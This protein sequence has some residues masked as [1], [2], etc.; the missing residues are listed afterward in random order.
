MSNVPRYHARLGSEGM[1]FC[2][3]AEYELFEVIDREFNA[4]LVHV[5]ASVVSRWSL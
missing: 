2:V 1:T 3:G 4:G 5:N